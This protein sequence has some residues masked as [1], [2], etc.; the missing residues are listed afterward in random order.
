M[1]C[2]ETRIK[3]ITMP[4]RPIPAARVVHLV[5]PLLA[6]A[7]TGCG[8]LR[9]TDQNVIGQ[10]NQVHGSLEPA[11]IRDPVVQRYMDAIGDRIVQGAIALNE[12]GKEAKAQRGQDNSWMYNGGVK[13]HLVNSETLNAFTTGGTHVYIYNQ[14]FQDAA[15]EDELAAVMAHEFAHIYG[16][17]VHS[18]MSRQ[19]GV[20]GLTALGAVAGYAVGG[21]ESGGQ[22]A[23]LGAGALGAVGQTLSQGFSRDDENE[24]D[25]LGFRFYVRGGWDPDR[26]ADFFKQMID[27][28][29]DKGGGGSHPALKDRVAQTEQRVADLSP[30]TAERWRR[31]PVADPREFEDIKARAREVARN[32]PSDKTL[33]AAKLMLQAFPSCV[34][35]EDQPDQRAAQQELLRAA[36]EVE[37]APAGRSARQAQ[38]PRR[39]SASIPARRPARSRR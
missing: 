3:E 8:F 28:G 14:L 2:T 27:K 38:Q 33:A 34:T 39:A 12:E 32:V 10:A 13:F 25:K 19:Y 16:R 5:L 9:P 7:S 26:F 20:M 22:Y 37:P 31:R 17:H 11:V 23:G 15:T 6:L 18:G 29:L 35:P 21:K 24:A 4:R 30:E 36:E 1:L